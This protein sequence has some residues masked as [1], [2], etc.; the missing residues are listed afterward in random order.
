MVIPDMLVFIKLFF[1]VCKHWLNRPVRNILNI[2]TSQQDQLK[3]S[4]CNA[5]NIRNTIRTFALIRQGCAGWFCLCS[6]LTPQNLLKTLSSM[7][8]VSDLKQT[9][10]PWDALFH[11]LL[12]DP[13]APPSL[14][15]ISDSHVFKPINLGNVKQLMLINK[16]TEL[17]VWYYFYRAYHFRLS[18]LNSHA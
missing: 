9:L 18:F 10:K 15:W 8:T 7:L 13:N 14:F 12:K 6:V 1:F 11:C 16:R 17:A 2:Q 4:G 5:L 3:N